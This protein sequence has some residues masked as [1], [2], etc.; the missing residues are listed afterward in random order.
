MERQHSRRHTHNNWQPFAPGGAVRRCARFARSKLRPAPLSVR[1]RGDLIELVRRATATAQA[2]SGKSIFVLTMRG[3]ARHVALESILGARLRMDGHHVTFLLCQDSLTFCMYGSVNSPPDRRRNCSAC[4]RSRFSVIEGS[5]PH[6]IIPAAC[7]VEPAFLAEVGELGLEGCSDFEYH[8]A[9]YGRLVEPSVIWFLRRSRLTEQDVSTYREAI[10][11]AHAVRRFLEALI[12]ERQVDAVVGLNGDFL[13]GKVAGWVLP[14]HAIRWVTYDYAFDDRVLVGLNRS[15]WDDLTFDSRPQLPPVGPT[16]GERRRAERLLK[17]W[18]RQGGYQGHLYWSKRQTS[19]RSGL[20]D[21]DR[22]PS[23]VAFTNL[24]FESSVIGK[25]RVFA[26]QLEWLEALLGFFGEHPEWRL[27]VRIH[28]AEVRDSHWRPRESLYDFLADKDALAPNVCVIAPQQKVS[29]YAL[30]EAANAVL[31]YSSTIGMEM[32]DRGR[33]VI[34]AAHSH[35][36][37][38]GFTV[39]PET[40]AAYFEAITEA[41]QK[42]QT[43]AV[44]EDRKKLVDYVA[45]LFSRRLIPFEPVSSIGE[46]W[47]R[48]NMK[49]P[50]ALAS[51]RNE[52]LNKLCALVAEGQRWW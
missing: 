27:V 9:P 28:P 45:W 25:D 44:V 40:Q 48:V 19:W 20:Q 38:R 51:P 16:R 39:D 41:L 23:A 46:T 22:R 3:W 5:F 1:N 36:T 10:I 30:G 8:D 24:T 26:G 43:S 4:I 15:C 18:R 33:T 17:A 6:L 49:T 47:P 52:G 13:A 11:S 14:R 32:V 21:S 2:A 34:T 50:W 42:P 31:V 37:G 29:S 35:Y 7:N 12:A